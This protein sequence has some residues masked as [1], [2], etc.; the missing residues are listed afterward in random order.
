LAVDGNLDDWPTGGSTSLEEGNATFFQGSHAST[1]DLSAQIWSQ[2]DTNYLYFAFHLR[3]DVLVTDSTDVWR[4]DEVE[5]ALDGL[6]N[7]A[8]NGSDD[9]QFT[10]NPDYRVT[11][12]GTPISTLA[13]GI[14]R[15]AEGWNLEVALPKATINAGDLVANKTLGVTFGLHD[16]DD[17]GNWDTYMIWEGNNV[18][19]G[20]FGDL[21]LTNPSPPTPT[22][23]GT[24]LP[25]ATHTRTSTPTWT[26]TA[27]HVPTWTPTPTDRP[28]WTPT[29][30]PQAILHLFYVPSIAWAEPVP[31]LPPQAPSLHTIANMDG[32]GSYPVTWSNAVLATNYNLQEA[33]NSVFVAPS[34]LYVG[35]GT[36]FQVND[37]GPTRYFYRVK[38]VNSSGESGWSNVESVD[39]VWE[40]EP[41]NVFTE[42]NGPILSD[43]IYYGLFPGSGDLNDY[44]AFDVSA[45][46]SVEVW[47]TSIG[48]GHNYDILLRDDIGQIPGAYSGNLGNANE[49]IFVPA[50]AMGRY[51]IRVINRSESSSQQPYQV[52]VVYE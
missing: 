37:H 48:S 38:A 11:D 31:V 6:H 27:T 35:T 5:L 12:Y 13:V 28:T 15:T 44:Y 41:N 26:P 3:D 40:R 22:P 17:G 32:D 19:T 14:Q 18:Q 1:S 33:T 45:P 4:D 21:V 25:T 9:H 36:V 16:D 34:T 23:T 8:S 29:N 42:A 20:I 51:Y 43:V 2:W 52:R 30:T 10:V 47:L 7:G 50:L 24:R 49:H 39:V 46:H